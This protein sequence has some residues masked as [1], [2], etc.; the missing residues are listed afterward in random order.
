LVELLQGPNTPGRN[1]GTLQLWLDGRLEGSWTDA[2]FFDAGQRVTLNR[3]EIAP[4]YGG[5]AN[6]VPKEQWIRVGPLLV[7]SR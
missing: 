5:G 7:R 3:L 1:D 4:I 6:P 2:R